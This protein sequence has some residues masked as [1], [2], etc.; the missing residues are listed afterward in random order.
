MTLSVRGKA[1]AQSSLFSDEP[2]TC[3]SRLAGDGGL[4][5]CIDLSGAIAGKPAPTVGCTQVCL[6]RSRLA[7]DS[8]PEPCIDLSGAIAGKPAPTVGC[9][10]FCLRRSRLAGDSG[11]EPCIDL[12]DAIAGKPAPTVCLCRSRLAGDGGPE[13]CI[14]LSGAIAGKPAPT[15]GVWVSCLSTPRDSARSCAET[16][17]PAPR[18][19]RSRLPRRSAQSAGPRASVSAPG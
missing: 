2:M 7:G 8:G 10:Q 12:S 15:R 16:P 11:P 14:D 13:P 6:C 1:A 4:E 18:G 3:R 5:P 9:T 19:F 17:G